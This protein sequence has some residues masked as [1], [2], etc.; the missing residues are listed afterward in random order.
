MGIFFM[1][2]FF[3]SFYAGSEGA[4]VIIFLLR[5]VFAMI[6]GRNTVAFVIGTKITSNVLWLIL[7]TLRGVVLASSILLTINFIELKKEGKL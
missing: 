7:H 1:K 4:T 6:T 2:I 3:V 5:L